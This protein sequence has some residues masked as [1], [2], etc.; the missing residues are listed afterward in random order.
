MPFRQPLQP[1]APDPA[2]RPLAKAKAHHKAGRLPE[3]E[4]LYRAAIR[5]APRHGDA[6][7]LLGV[8]Y[9]ERGKPEQAFPLLLDGVR[10]RK[11]ILCPL[12]ANE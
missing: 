6:L 2:A 3:A 4:R 11:C 9:L 8:L 5:I 10:T 12:R 1:N 7:R